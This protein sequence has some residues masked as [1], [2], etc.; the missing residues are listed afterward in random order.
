MNLNLA[1]KIA[2]VSGSSKGIGFAIASR[3]A[4]EGARVIVN[5]RSDEAVATAL[6][7]IRGADPNAK[8]EG[9]TGDLSTA[10]AVATLLSRFQAVD[11]LVNNLGIFEPK[12]FEE[13]TR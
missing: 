3:L 13:I 10:E 9:F 7:E 6:E 4:G 12:A 5:G 1:D 11:I 8:V 2:L